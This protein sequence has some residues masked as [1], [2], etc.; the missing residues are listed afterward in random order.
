MA[1]K[2]SH[3]S[4]RSS[5][6]CSALRKAN[7]RSGRTCTRSNMWVMRSSSRK[8][9]RQLTSFFDQRSFRFCSRPPTNSSSIPISAGIFLN[10]FFA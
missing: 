3:I 2:P 8:K 1:A 9:F 5:T 4:K 7:E 10:G 6:H